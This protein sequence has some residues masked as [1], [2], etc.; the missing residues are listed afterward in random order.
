[1]FINQITATLNLIIWIPLISAIVSI[2]VGIA[3][4]LKVRHDNKEKM[5]TK[6]FVLEKVA[7][8]DV[9]VVKLEGVIREHKTDNIREHDDIKREFTSLVGSISSKIDTIITLMPRQQ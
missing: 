4:I 6:I 9:S 7:A 2:I 1:M 3:T 8:V 5:A